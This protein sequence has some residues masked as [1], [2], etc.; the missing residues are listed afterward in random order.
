MTLF[1]KMLVELKVT[2]NEKANIAL[3]KA[4]AALTIKGYKIYVPLMEYNDPF[5]LLASKDGKVLKFE[6]KYLSENRPIPKEMNQYSP[7]GAAVKIKKYQSK[8]FDYFAI[9]LSSIDIVI[10]P[11][12]KFK[13]YKIRTSIPNS[14]TPFYWYE[15]FLDLTDKVEKKNCFDFG[16]PP[17]R[18]GR[19]KKQ[20]K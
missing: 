8:D 9:Y 7:K 17:T 10:F 5:D 4:I 19:I 11:G 16:Q 20:D 3:T 2:T 6:V 13:G 18:K 14:A 1:V 15:D 12:I